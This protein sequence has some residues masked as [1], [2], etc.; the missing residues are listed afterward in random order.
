MKSHQPANLSSNSKEPPKVNNNPKTYAAR[1][2]LQDLSPHIR[3]RKAAQVIEELCEIIEAE[4]TPPPEPSLDWTIW[5]LDAG[6]FQL[7]RHQRHDTGEP[8]TVA[9]FEGSMADCVAALQAIDVIPGVNVN[10]G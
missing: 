5:P 7:I 4:P 6:R 3:T 9:M 1:R 2:Y 10:L 8:Y